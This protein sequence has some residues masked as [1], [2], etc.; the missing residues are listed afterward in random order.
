MT[1]NALQ[2]ENIPNGVLI[3]DNLE[4]YEKKVDWNIVVAIEDTSQQLALQIQAECD[5]FLN[6]LEKI[7]KDGLKVH[8][9]YWRDRLR[10]EMYKSAVRTKRG[11]LDIIGDL[12]NSL[13]GT[14]R[15]SDVKELQHYV[16]E[17]R[18]SIYG[19]THKLEKLMTVANSSYGDVM[20]NRAALRK[21]NRATQNLQNYLRNAQT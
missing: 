21:L 9:A 17:N 20:A 14:A 16:N 8:Q 12:S 2:I 1:C 13:F 7:T 18:H 3:Q 15:D 6:Y 19:I 4:L 10:V 11:A 5:N